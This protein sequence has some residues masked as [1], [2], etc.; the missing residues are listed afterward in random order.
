MTDNVIETINMESIKYM[1]LDDDDGGKNE[2]ESVSDQHTKSAVEIFPNV[3]DKNYDNTYSN[4]G[5]MNGV[6]GSEPEPNTGAEDIQN[7]GVI[8]DTINGVSVRRSK[9]IRDNNLRLVS[10]AR[11]TKNKK[12]KR[13][14][15]YEEYTKVRRVF[16]ANKA[17]DTM[18]VKEGIV[19][20]QS[21]KR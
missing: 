10:C 20:C 18:S 7:Y 2:V 3:I 16:M 12:R 8:N 21:L 1:R 14:K 13:M 11:T 15:D 4:V 17:S 19:E 5:A 9:R 6:N